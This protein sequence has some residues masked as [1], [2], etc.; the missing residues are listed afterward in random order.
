[1]D[2][3]NILIVDDDRFVREILTDILESENFKTD[4]AENGLEAL[5]KYKADS[6][7]FDLI[8]SDINMPIMG[9]VD[10]IKALRNDVK[11]EVPVVVLSGNNEV[12]IAIDAITSGASEY[13]LKDE[14]LQETIVL[15]INKAIE[16]KR[17][18]DENRALVEDITQKNKEMTSIIQRMTELGTALSAEKNFQNLMELV[19]SNARQ[20]TYA[21]A[22]TL[23]LIEDGKLCFKI[24]QND[25]LRIYLGGKSNEE[26]K[27]PPVDIK[28][29]N[30][31]GYSTLKKEVVNIPD[32]YSSELFDFTGPKKFD[33]TSN[34]RSKS[35]LVVPMVSRANEVVGVLQLL[36]SKDPST[37]EVVTFSSS[38]EEY[39]K[40]LGSQAAV[41]IN[42]LLLEAKAEKLFEEILDV[43]NYNESILESL[44]NGVITLDA[45]NKIIKCNAAILRILET[46]EDKVINQSAQHFFAENNRWVLDNLKR[47]IRMG[48]PAIVMD[49]ELVL[50][51]EK[52]IPLNLTAV[53]LKNVKSESIGSM[54]VLEDITSEKRMK[55][56]L[57]RYMDKDVAEQLMEGGEDML[58]GKSQE[59]SVLFSDIRGFT[60]LTEKLGPADTVAMLNEY[61]TEMVEYIFK[62]KGILDKYIGD[63]ILAVFGVP[64]QHDQDPENAVNAAIGMVR[65]LKEFNAG[66]VIQGKDSID[67]GIGVNTDS[68]LA[69]NIGSEKRMD[70]T[71]IGDGVNLAS[72]L[73]G[74]TKVYGAKILISA[75]TKNKL[76]E[77]HI[78]REVDKLVVKGKTQPVS[79]FEILDFHEEATFPRMKEC[80]EIFIEGYLCFHKREWDEGVMFFEE[81]LALNPKDKPSS[82]YIERSRLYKEEPPAEDWDGSYVMTTK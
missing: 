38:S 10:L 37:G 22:G 76:A 15:A 71:V 11:S 17:I 41:A 23:Y 48:S 7:Q 45:E 42:N 25:T 14:N 31:S 62:Y 43:K 40:A 13:I 2:P 24:V 19:I 50:N 59:A 68:V 82:L 78:Y 75:T 35:M 64:F 70:Y 32:V 4:T 47:V 77:G 12:A 28:E 16:K 54:L 57:A 18:I 46:Q 58:G 3:I 5:N 63:A 69:G 44:T 66:R 52:S 9:G 81:V 61:F 73:E 56:T 1:M 72:R 55:G 21:D 39:I 34:Y 65:S 80:L 74:A 29:S 20:L 79:I 30:V 26:I 6:G 33:Q 27:F 49:T 67:I 60:T 36:N 53:P 8:V 51:D